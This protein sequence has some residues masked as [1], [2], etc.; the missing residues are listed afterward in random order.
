MAEKKYAV[1]AI[2]LDSDGVLAPT[3][4]Y[5]N[6]AIKSA[7]RKFEQ[8]DLAD[9]DYKEQ[10]GKSS[11]ETIFLDLVRNER[12]ASGDERIIEVMAKT[13]YRSKTEFYVEALAYHA[14]NKT[15]KA[16]PGIEEL[17]KEAYRNN[18]PLAVAS[19]SNSLAVSTL[20]NKLEFDEYLKTLICHDPNGKP[21]PDTYRTAVGV[22]LGWDFKE[23]DQCVAIEDT[24]NGALSALKTGLRVLITT[25]EYTD[26]DEVN[27]LRNE[28]R[29]RVLWLPNMPNA[30]DSGAIT[31]DLIDDFA[32]GRITLEDF[33]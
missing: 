9:K 15:L 13:L 8:P 3:R 12:L 27:E 26:R 33:F 19:A 20:I 7:F 31:L 11:S 5:H 22:L 29:D 30:P 16:C 18:I 17:L 21:A 25:S 28:Y 6:E 10:L 32:A 23:F 14:K 2:F 24:G 1:K 4:D